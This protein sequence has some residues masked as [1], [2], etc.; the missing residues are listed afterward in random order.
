L[1]ISNLYG[2]VRQVDKTVRVKLVKRTLEFNNESENIV[3]RRLMDGD[4]EYECE[5]VSADHVSIEP[6]APVFVP[7]Q[8]TRY[9][10][11]EFINNVLLPP[12]G[13]A[14]GYTTIPVD[15][16][17]FSVKNSEYK[18]VDVFSE[19][20]VKYALYGPKD[21]GLIA[22]YYRSRFTHNPVEPAYFMEALVPVEVVNSYSKWINL[23][24]LLLDSYMLYFYYKHKGLAY[25]QGIRVNITSETTATI[26]YAKE[27]KKGLP[28]AKKPIKMSILVH[29]YRKTEMIWGL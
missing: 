17:V 20:K 11:V 6:V 27:K 3:Y 9:I 21:E 16:A 22:R 14:R 28:E 5:I 25:T 7:K 18:V 13:V 24:Q 26:E 2:K 29:S 1:G 4:L 19:N 10:L 23:R 8:L 12:E 15:I